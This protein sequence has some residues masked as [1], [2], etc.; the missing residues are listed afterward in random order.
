MGTP[1]LWRLRGRRVRWAATVVLAV[2]AGTFV[3]AIVQRAEHT[4]AAFGELRAAPVATRELAV[5]T[6][7]APGDV[8]WTDLPA[9]VVPDGVAPD[10]LG[11]TVTEPIVTGEVLLQ[12][13]LSGGS[14]TGVLGL[15]P[16]G[17]RALAVPVEPS[18]PVLLVG[19][20]VDVYSPA[21]LSP[22]GLS[23]DGG[24]ATSSGV[25]RVA[26]DGVVVATDERATTIAVDADEAPAVARAILDG[27]V[28][29]ALVA[30]G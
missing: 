23:G 20:R 8:R 1:I 21:E 9:A 30:P 2:V 4:R 14:G 13:R 12:R 25:R 27:A 22:G 3:A 24:R 15:L 10:P 17:G 28:A 7:V 26:R 11:R 5:G 16:P 6:E 19:D 18:T 29:L